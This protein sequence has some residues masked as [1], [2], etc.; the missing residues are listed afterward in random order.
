MCEVWKDIDGFENYQISDLGRI[1]SKQRIV[2][3]QNGSYVKSEKI[4]KTHVMKCGYLA[5]VLRDKEQKRHLLKIHRLLAENFIPNPNNYPFINHIDGDKTNCNLDN[6]EWCTPKQNT[7]HA[8]R[9]G[10]RPKVTGRNIQR[11]CK[12]NQDTKK[13]ED[14]YESFSEAARKNGLNS[15]GGIYSA[16]KSK[17]N[18]GGFFWIKENDYNN[19]LIKEFTK[20]RNEHRF[21]LNGE[22]LN[23]N[24]YAKRKGVSRESVYRMINAG[25][26][27]DT[28]ICGAQGVERSI[29]EQ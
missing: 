2:T 7:Q 23:L 16:C 22:V 26:I 10:L 27:K 12:V 17:R 14:V 8:I 6:L 24:Q 19:G 28:R 13:I 18:Y 1:K 25:K 15:I 5:I 11:I 3:N 29:C 21:L 9:T 20:K 4:L